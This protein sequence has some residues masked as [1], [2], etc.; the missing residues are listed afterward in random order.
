MM[1][2]TYLLHWKHSTMS[3]LHLPVFEHIPYDVKAMLQRFLIL[4]LKKFI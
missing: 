2:T 1:Y 3:S 4:N